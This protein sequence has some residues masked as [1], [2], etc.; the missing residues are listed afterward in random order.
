[1]PVTPKHPLRAFRDANGLNQQQAAS[2]VGISQSMWCLLERGRAFA[3]PRV[4][5]R[6]SDVT[7]IGMESLLNF[8]ANKSSRV[9]PDSGAT[10]LENVKDLP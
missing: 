9:S 7:K 10:A 2:L 8:T 1:M 6:I 5:R 4:A 3:S